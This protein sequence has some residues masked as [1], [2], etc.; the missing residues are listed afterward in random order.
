MRLI[1]DVV[2]GQ[3]DVRNID[4]PNY[5]LIEEIFDDISTEEGI[6]SSEVD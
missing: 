4:I 5:E 2:T 6:D 3:I 1:S